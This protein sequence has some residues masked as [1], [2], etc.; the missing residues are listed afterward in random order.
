[1]TGDEAD[2]EFVRNFRRDFTLPD[3]KDGM[4]ADLFPLTSKHF[5]EYRFEL[6]GDQV[7]EGQRAWLIGFGP[8]DATGYDWAG[9]ALIDQAEFQ[10]VSIYTKLSRRLPFAVRNILGIDVPGIGFNVRYRRFDNDVWFPVSFGTEFRLRAL[11]FFRRNVTVS[12]ENS[13]FR[14]ADVSSE[15]NYQVNSEM[16]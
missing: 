13:G 6:R 11:H 3:S 2:A 7:V 5:A 10:P 1:M 8:T 9:E 14:K 4:E 15:I 16:K 12:L